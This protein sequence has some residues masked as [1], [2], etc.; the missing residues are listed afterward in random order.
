MFLETISTRCGEKD[1]PLLRT[2]YDTVVASVIFYA[3]LC[4]GCEFSERDRK[5]RN[6]LV[7]R[8]GSVLG[9]TLAPVEVV[10]ER[11]ILDKLA[12]I[13]S[14]SSHP[15]RETVAA[16]S[17]SFSKRLLHPAIKKEHF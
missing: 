2:F 6:K 17:S 7:G 4:W 13:M 15:L 9:W 14:N 1:H 5:R 3:V 8:D 16:Q 11:R 12:S 10:E